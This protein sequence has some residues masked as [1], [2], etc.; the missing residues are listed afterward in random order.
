[1]K[2]FFNK[3]I[4]LCA[5]LII[6]LC[7]I[8]VLCFNSITTT[9]SDNMRA[10]IRLPNGNIAYGP[11]ED[12]KWYQSA[13]MYKITISDKTYHVHTSNAIIIEGE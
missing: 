8:G 6:I 2:R 12:Y 9:G 5:A 10:I 13:Q 7:I 4:A 3:P 1:M 11:V